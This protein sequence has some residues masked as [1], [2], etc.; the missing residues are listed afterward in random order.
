MV[1]SKWFELRFY[2]SQELLDMAQGNPIKAAKILYSI[3]REIFLTV[4]NNHGIEDF[5]ILDEINVGFILLRVNVAKDKAE[6]IMKEI[7]DRIR[8]RAKD[9]YHKYF[10]FMKEPKI[11]EWAPEDDARSRIMSAAGRIG[12]QLPPGK[13]WKVAGM[14][15]KIISWP[16]FHLAPQWKYEYE[17]L[18]SKVETF[19]KFMV[20]VLGRF[21]REFLKEIPEYVDDRWLMSLFIH[22]LLNSISIWHEN[23]VRMFPYV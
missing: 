23:E 4:L 19:T 10:D 7:T 12:L 2:I 6:L 11:V 17:D 15:C 14:K 13:A 5:V 9:G 20:K 3:K 1:K 16:Y 21:T 22:L 8:S 18:N